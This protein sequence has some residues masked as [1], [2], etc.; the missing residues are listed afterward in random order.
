MGDPGVG[1]TPY[2]C[3][4]IPKYGLTIQMLGKETASI[5]LL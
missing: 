1:K 5:Q 3:P 2:G 4:I